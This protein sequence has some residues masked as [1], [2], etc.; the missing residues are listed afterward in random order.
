MPDSAEP[1]VDWAALATEL[2]EYPRGMWRQAVV[3]ATVED[4]WGARAA[5]L[6]AEHSNL[7]PGGAKTIG[8]CV[9]LPKPLPREEPLDT[10]GESMSDWNT[11]EI[12]EEFRD[13]TSPE[14]IVRLIVLKV[15]AGTPI[16]LV[17]ATV[18]TLRDG[19]DG[20]VGVA[21]DI[22]KGAGGAI[23]GAAEGIGGAIEGIFGGGKKEE[24]PP[25]PPPEEPKKKR[26]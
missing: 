21:G 2:A 13:L 26:R 1:A 25:P 11:Y 22:L 16:R 7:L 17:N 12:D 10:S 19:L 9:C 6:L 3:D 14:Q 8:L 5:G 15:V 4:F 23:K 24:P 18:E 20:V